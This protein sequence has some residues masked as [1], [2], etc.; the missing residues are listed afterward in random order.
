MR[1]VPLVCASFVLFT[2]LGASRAAAQ[3]GRALFLQH[4]ASCHGETGDGHGTATL[5][6]AARSFKEG[7]FSYGN[8][9]DAV[10]RTITFGIPGTPMPAAPAVLNEADRN[11]LASYVL[12]LGPVTTEAGTAESRLDV[13]DRPRIARGKLDPIVEGAPARP[14]GLCV[15]TTDGFTFEYRTDDVR[16]LG[17]RQGAFVDRADWR[18]RGGDALKPLGTLLLVAGRGDPAPTFSDPRTGAPFG[19]RLASTSTE[20][21]VP[22]LGYRLFEAGNSTAIGSVGEAPSALHGTGGSGFTRHLSIDS[23]RAVRVRAADAGPAWVAS[24]ISWIVRRRGDGS[25]EACSV[26]GL[27]AGEVLVPDGG[28]AE[29]VLGPGAR[30]VEIRTLL[31]PRW[32]DAIQARWLA[33]VAP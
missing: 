25:F 6:R 29:F 20:H 30:E 28:G 7:G 33:G 11:A 1:L 21:G 22:L 2:S 14:R 12:A 8:T 9:Q 31:A 17:V 18:G 13:T 3:D 15:G 16:L 26:T 24:G 27:R 19:A 4:C 10:V 23:T 32:D 5:D